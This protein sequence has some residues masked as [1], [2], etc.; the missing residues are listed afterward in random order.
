MSRLWKKDMIYLLFKFAFYSLLLL[1]F[2]VILVNLFPIYIKIQRIVYDW[3]R[4]QLILSFFFVN[5]WLSFYV[6]ISVCKS[7]G[8]CLFLDF[9]ILTR[10]S[11]HIS[12][13]RSVQRIFSLFQ[14][15]GG[16]FVSPKSARCDIFSRCDYLF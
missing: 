3:I 15:E 8:S 2:I 12:V 16:L 6:A 13:T 9:C 10:S 1:R 11:K 4:D 5:S 7:V 14:C